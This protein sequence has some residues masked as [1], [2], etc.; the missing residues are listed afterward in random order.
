VQVPSGSS[1]GCRAP[2]VGVTGGCEPTDMHAGNLGSLEK[3]QALLIVEN[4][5]TTPPDPWQLYIF[6]RF[7]M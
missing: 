1:T 5:S 2:G 4:V 6:K 3:Q 7:E